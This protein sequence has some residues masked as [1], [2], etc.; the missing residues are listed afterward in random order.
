MRDRRAWGGGS[1][2]GAAGGGGGSR[3]HAGG[4]TVNTLR[5]VTTEEDFVWANTGRRKKKTKAVNIEG[6]K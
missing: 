3:P 5:R 1:L 2:C 6:L 4:Y